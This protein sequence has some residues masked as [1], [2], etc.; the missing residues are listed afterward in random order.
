MSKAGQGH[1][2]GVDDGKQSKALPS[3]ADIPPTNL[4]ISEATVE[5]KAGEAKDAE[6][7]QEEQK[8]NQVS[9]ENTSVCFAHH[10]NQQFVENTHLMSHS[11]HDGL[12]SLA[13][14]VRVVETVPGTGTIQ[15]RALDIDVVSS[16][17][18]TATEQIRFVLCKDS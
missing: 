5:T 9:R 7:L 10:Q 12:L 11:F 6:C 1:L 18:S 8:R 4:T 15:L 14:L 16:T 3:K 17:S 2:C 13:I